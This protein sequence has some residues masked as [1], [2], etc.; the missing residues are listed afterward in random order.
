MTSLHLISVKKQNKTKSRHTK[1]LHL[2]ASFLCSC[3]LISLTSNQLHLKSTLTIY[4]HDLDFAEN[5]SLAQVLSPGIVLLITLYA[6]LGPLV[7][8]CLAISSTTPCC[9]LCFPLGLPD[10]SVPQ[11]LSLLATSVPEGPPG[12]L[13][14][15]SVS[16][17]GCPPPLSLT[18]AAD[19]VAAP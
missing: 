16:G 5:R 17:P 9:L 4:S 3:L 10:A 15:S 1:V 19:Q 8:I 12:G 13:G 11:P 14:C 2:N 18:A 6:L 7:S